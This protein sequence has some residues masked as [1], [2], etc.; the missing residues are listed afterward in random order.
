MSASRVSCPHCGAAN[1]GLN[2][3]CVSCGSKLAAPAT[4][5]E[6]APTPAYDARRRDSNWPLLVTMGAVFVLLMVVVAEAALIL[7]SSGAAREVG[8][9]LSAIEGKVFVQ[10]GGEGDW[11]EIAEGFIVDAGDRIRVA[12][13]S[14]GVLTFLENTTSE[15][16]SFTE[17][18]VTDLQ[19]AEDQPAVI[20]LDM[21]VGEIWNR[22]GD[23]PS[24]SLHEVTTMAARVV[25][26]GTEFGIKVD[27]T[28]T[29]WLTGH[30]GTA[31]VSGGG[32]TV[33]LGAGET[34]V[35]EAGAVPEPFEEVA[36]VPSPA[37]EDAPP[38]APSYALQGI[39]LPTFLNEPLPT[40]TPTSTATATTAL[41]A[42]ATSTATPT[43][44]ATRM[45]CPNL[46][47][48]VPSQCYPRRACGLEWDSSG[49]IPPGYEFA[50]EY[51]A[52]EANWTRLPVPLDPYWYQ[53]GGHFK[54]VIHGPGAGTWYWRI[55]LVSAA[56]VSGP[57]ECCG[58]AHAIIHAR[59]ERPEEEEDSPD[60][61][62]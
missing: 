46:S 29:V 19:L 33:D 7:M 47:I 3:Y 40:G 61:D 62:Y 59:D 54:A 58:P 18:T 37:P 56:D 53:E 13:G 60:Y 44:T 11:M 51:S 50:I 27:G 2:R 34:L 25:S 32:Q 42:T 30:E 43:A 17:L 14:Q 36:L 21:E 20:S 4:A 10:K 8:A 9:T 26:V 15:L 41:T 52:D 28:G 39:D 45:A 22:I 12:G 6:A 57:S 5:P 49:P 35:V 31:S 55:C 23:L 38:A 1:R 48:N 16:R 24:G